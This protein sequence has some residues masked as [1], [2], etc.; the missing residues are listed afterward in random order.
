MNLQ[1][2]LVTL[3]FDVAVMLAGWLVQQRRHNS[4]ISDLLWAGCISMSALYYG[5]VA[6]GAML[7]RLLVALMGGLWGF[8]LFMHLL[9]RMLV[10]PKDSRQRALEAQ[11]GDNK[12]LMLGYF[13]SKG[14]A[15]AL[16][17]VPLFIAAS[18][19][20]DL[21]TPWTILAAALYLIGL[22]GQTYADIQLTQFREQPRH[23]AKSCR[24]GL[25][26][27][28]RHP[29]H[30][31]AFVH[32]LSY[33]PLA[34]GV[35]W[36]PWTLTW[37]APVLTVLWWQR[38]L[39]AIETEA[40]KLRGEDYRDYC[41]AT[42]LVVP[43]PPRGWPNDAPTASSWYTPPPPSRSVPVASQRGTPLP[44]ARITPSPLA[45]PSKPLTG[46]TTPKPDKPLDQRNQAPTTPN[47]PS[48]MSAID[49]DD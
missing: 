6:E 22:A 7:P 11:L 2:V 23:Q 27:Y 8:R 47:P 35:P 17:S 15:A 1:P 41:R 49:A 5:L 16:F 19:P 24:R 44:G 30:F 9:Q 45:R 48:R 26:R 18:N 14:V 43:W 38:R 12:L 34:V 39:P 29:N 21:A 37:L 28:S 4:A 40:E 20:M 33:A 25:W 36:G 13:V 31:Y 3:G 10:E 32:W 46:P 42:S